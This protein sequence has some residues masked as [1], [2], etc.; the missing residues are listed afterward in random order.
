V[1][2]RP[3]MMSIDGPDHTRVRKV[4]ARGL[5]PGD[6]AALETRIRELCH[7]LLD[8]AEERGTVEFMSEI[9]SRLPLQVICELVGIPEGPERDRYHESVGIVGD[10]SN[11]RYAE[12]PMQVLGA[13]QFVYEYASEL[14][15]VKRDCPAADLMSRVVAAHDA[16]M[17]SR[18]ELE[19]MLLMLGLGGD[20]TTRNALGHSLFAFHRFPEQWELLCSA[21]ERYI[22]ACVEEI[23]RWSTPVV[24]VRR[25]TTEDV[26]FHG[27]TIREGE[28]VSALY[29]SA[30]FDPEVF[31]RP[32]EFDITRSPNRHLSFGNGPHVCLG[33]AL[34]RLEI[35]TFMLALVERMQGFSVPDGIVYHADSFLRPVER[36][37]MEFRPRTRSTAG[38]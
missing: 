15:E 33:A 27:V 9:G 14:A 23:L 3:V 16:E 21:P 17:L 20:E 11:P 12:D 38:R 24:G 1:T 19:A 2:D 26:E 29:A 32:Y 36:M 30:N 25:T 31:D 10:S 34:G 8:H 37:T 4:V 7:E 18:K 5:R 6:I 28:P 35:R 13:A 22:D